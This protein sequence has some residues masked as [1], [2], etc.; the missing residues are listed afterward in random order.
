MYIFKVSKRPAGVVP[1]LGYNIF[2]SEIFSLKDLF[3]RVV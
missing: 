1:R 3:L 2:V